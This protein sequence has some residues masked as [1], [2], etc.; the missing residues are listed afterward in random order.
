MPLRLEPLID[1]NEAG[2]TLVFVQGWPDDAS[3]WDDAVAALG[4]RYRCVRINLPNHDGKMT[5]WGHGTEEIVDALV[6]LFREVG[7][8]R[9][10]TLVLHDWGSYWGHAAHRRCPEVVARVVGLDVAPHFEPGPKAMVGIMAYQWWL[11]GAFVVGGRMGDRMTRRFAKMSG[12]PADPARLDARMNY[13]YRNVWQDLLS[14]RAGKLTEGYWPTCPLLFVYGERKPFPF[15]SK[16]WVDHVRSVAHG[17]V[18]GLPCGHWVM[19]HPEFIGVLARWLE[20]SGSARGQ[21]A[22]FG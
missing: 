19:R 10:V 2:E 1:G 17:E 11:L 22:T 8:A 4:A 6:R 15:H 20:A 18:V 9:P 21:H 3:L 14:G 7:A 5:R 13:P 16:A 12:A